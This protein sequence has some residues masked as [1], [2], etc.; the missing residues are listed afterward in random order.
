MKRIFTTLVLAGIFLTCLISSVEALT[1]QTEAANSDLEGEPVTLRLKVSSGGVGDEPSFPLG[2]AQGTVGETIDLGT[3]DSQPDRQTQ[4]LVEVPWGSYFR[5]VSLD[6][7]S[8][9]SVRVTV[10]SDDPSAEVT[11][12]RH[13]MLV[14]PFPGRVMIREFLVL[15]NDGDGL[16]GGDQ[17]L[18]FDLPDD[19]SRIIPGPGMSGS[20][21]L[22]QEGNEYRYQKKI[23]PGETI[24][25]FFYMLESPG[26]RY[27]L[28]RRMTI[29]TER[30]V[31][32][33]PKYD[34]LT[35]EPS[36]LQKMGGGPDTKSGRDADIY[37][38]RDLRTGD[39]IGL[40]FTGLDDVS[41]MQ[42]K[43]AKGK[44]GGRTGRD[45]AEENNTRPSSFRNVSWPLMLGIGF[46]LLIFIG[47]YAYVQYRLQERSEE[48]VESE[49]LV[50]ELARLDQEFE[51]GAVDEPFYKR[52][53]RR[54][55][56]KLQ[57]S[58]SDESSSV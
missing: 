29:P 56:K 17:S 5:D 45:Q 34:A 51:D 54:W 9:G 41:P 52:T 14:Q 28:T 22:Q 37:G 20:E 25:G 24:V 44:S 23:A 38:A 33:V 2:P 7:L 40:T 58:E 55:K 53:R 42:G 19:L 46:S 10:Y 32:S 6:E 1:V 16:A 15:R 3:L 35:V 11:V 8:E 31:F 30:I 4:L 49:F 57:E 47:S 36:G 39:T 50:Q 21:D 27:E 43:K 26:D 12:D 48:S 18:T 13:G